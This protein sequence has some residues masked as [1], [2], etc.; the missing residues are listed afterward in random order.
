ME[1]ELYG[2]FTVWV[3]LLHSIVSRAHNSR[4]DSYFFFLRIESLLSLTVVEFEKHFTQKCEKYD[5]LILFLYRLYDS[6]INI[7]CF[8][9]Q[10][11]IEARIS[12]LIEISEWY[13]ISWYCMIIRGN[14]SLNNSYRIIRWFRFALFISFK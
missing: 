13:R 6:R 8:I 1:H 14:V 3:R 2:Y 7:Y 4:L 9:V 11:I 5:T 10:T 12:V